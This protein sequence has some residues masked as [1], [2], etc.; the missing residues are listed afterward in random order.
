MDTEKRFA[1]YGGTFDPVH[2]GHLSIA[3][4]VSELFALDQVLFIPAFIAPHKRDV[5]SA[6]AIQRYAMLVLATQD[7]P[8][9]YISTIELDA[10]EK[11][12]TIETLSRL[13]NEFG[14]GVELFFIMGADS[15]LDIK[16]WRDWE[17]LFVATNHIVVARPDYK[18]KTDHVTEAIRERVI[19]VRGLNR[20]EVEKI[21]E[22]AD[23]HRI[24]VTD[25]VEMDVSASRIRQEVKEGRDGW[26]GDVPASV[27][28]YIKKY[29]L[30]REV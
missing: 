18:L 26:T 8:E 1:I 30:Y 24:Y 6:P 4:K 27:A 23:E 14:E 29:R 10:P 28:E 21:L 2:N 16:T 9:F 12:Y 3:R 20:S 15:W 11:P 13:K 25:A 5:K 17:S 22:Q 7:E 19:D